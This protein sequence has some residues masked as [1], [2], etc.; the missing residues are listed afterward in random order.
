V[1]EEQRA[2]Q[3]WERRQ[4]EEQVRS[5]RFGPKPE[6]PRDP[7]RKLDAS[8]FN[9]MPLTPPEEVSTYL[10]TFAPVFRRTDT[11][12][13]AEYYLAGLLSDLRHKNG[14][15]IEAAVPG[16]TQQ[17]VHDFLVRSPWSA[18]ALDRA[19]VV[20]ALERTGH[21]GAVVDILVDEVGWGKKGDL[22][23]GVARQYVGAL[24]KVDNAQVVVSLHGHCDSLDLPLLAQLY[25]PQSWANEPG[26]RAMARIP[27]HVG[28]QTKPE[29]ALSLLDRARAW[30]L[31]CGT[32]FADAGYCDRDFVAGLRARGLPFCLGVKAT[33]RFWLPGEPW[34]PPVPPP[35]YAGRGRPAVG[36]PARPHVHTA[37]EIRAAL[38]AAA[39]QAIPYRDGTTGKPLVC[40]FAAQRAFLT[41]DGDAET[42][43]AVWLVLER[44]CA[45]DGGNGR[46]QY[47]LSAAEGTSLDELAHL[48]HRRPLIERN[49]YENAKQEVGLDDYQG[50][51]WAGLHH[52]VSMVWLALTFLILQ[53]R[54]LPA[55]PAPA[56]PAPSAEPSA[57]GPCGSGPSVLSFGSV[58][59]PT[60]LA[61]R[62]ATAPPRP[63][64]LWESV[65]AVHRRLIEWYRGMRFRELRFAAKPP[66]LPALT[67]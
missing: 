52:H 25:L 5:L 49:S 36:Q 57:H 3:A 47:I 67:T 31:R 12:R 2:R 54:L 55:P 29:I 66:P 23:V 59:V 35:P 39:W 18:E 64:Q 21:D 16:A 50:R 63:R 7:R 24:G 19:R 1:D 44:P 48:A 11:L 56:D 22:S 65:Q 62:A 38:P 17:G 45:A 53:R 40:E 43:E 61:L 8:Q 34:E 51:S 41:T 60:H 15:T 27:D 46:K 33:M 26:R 42:A 20:D 37:E 30:G 14:E 32:V 6:R 9:G 58:T 10:A 4:R 13:R 28:F